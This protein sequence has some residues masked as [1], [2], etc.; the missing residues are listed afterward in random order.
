TLD[1]PNVQTLQLVVVTADGRRIATEA[2]DMEHSI[3]M[4]DQG[5]LSFRQINKSKNGD[6][7]I[8]KT[9]VTDPGRS[10]ILI[11][12]NFRS[13]T[14]RPCAC[15]VYVYY[16]PSLNNSGMHDSAWTEGNWLLSRDGNT[17]SA[18]ISSSGFADGNNLAASR[19]ISHRYLGTS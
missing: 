16:D 17:A 1:V 9:Y 2:D 11:D 10:S 6:Y 13:L 3:Q 4:L 8:T 14:D 18:L 15:N 19:D 5:A 7:T 12:V